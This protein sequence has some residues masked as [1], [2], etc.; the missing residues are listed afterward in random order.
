MRPGQGLASPDLP[1]DADDY[2]DAD[3]HADVDVDAVEA[4]KADV[5]GRR[6]AAH[7]DANADVDAAEAEAAVRRRDAGRRRAGL[8]GGNA[9]CAGLDM[10]PIR[11][12]P[13]AGRPM[14]F[15]L[16]PQLAR[17]ERRK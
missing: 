6:R 9:I 17:R 7:A 4:A 15:D 16:S 5:A 13:G 8:P 14:R 1:A 10:L 12:G 11:N 3:A 2:T